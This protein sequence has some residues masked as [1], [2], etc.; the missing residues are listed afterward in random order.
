VTKLEGIEVLVVDDD[1]DNLELL[2]CLI[3]QEGGAVRGATSSREALRLL[4]QC[5]PHVLLLDISMPEGD[6][7]ELLAAIRGID[8]LRDIPAIAVTAHA[9]AGDRERCIDA[10]FVEH[11][12]KPYDGDALL[13][14]VARLST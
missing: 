13:A 12:T 9:Y 7:I 8:R 10:G 14:L 6:G 4:L 5:T 1:P 11:V 3:A 2:Q